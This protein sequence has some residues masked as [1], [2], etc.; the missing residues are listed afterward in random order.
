MKCLVVSDLQATEGS[1]RLRS[2]RTMPLQRWRVGRLMADLARHMKERGCHYLI[3][4]GD[5]TNERHSVPTG[6]IQ[7][8][9][10]GLHELAPNPILS[11]KL[12]GNHEQHQKTGLAHTGDMYAGYHR[13][14]ADREVVIVGKTAIICAA[15][16]ES[17][18]ELSQW[19]DTT[20]DKFNADGYK[21]LLLGHFQVA[22]SKMAGGTSD[23]GVPHS[24]VNK[25]TVA[26]LGHVHRPQKL[27]GAGNAHYVG[28]PFQQNFGE[29]GESKRLAVIDLVTLELEFIPL[30][31]YPV[32][33]RLSLDALPE[34]PEQLGEDRIEVTLNTDA[35]VD[36]FFKHPLAGM[37]TPVVAPQVSESTP[38]E[39]VEEAAATDQAWMSK[40]A[41]AT[42]IGVVGMSAE[43]LVSAGIALLNG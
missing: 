20:L 4:L 30:T 33:R 2:D 12:V 37:L 29:F 31:G 8:L 9:M 22:G 42:P 43:E 15:F 11:I 27:P 26:L 41:K 10:R 25:A 3:D 18:A 6:T 7:T 19:L 21:T 17:D 28:S 1:E 14:I 16:P 40:Y 39:P 36:A 32:Y 13:V 5:T 34:S 24:V 23:S 38:S 35:E